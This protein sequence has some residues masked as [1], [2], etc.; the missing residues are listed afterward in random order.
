MWHFIRLSVSND[1]IFQ[2]LFYTPYVIFVHSDTIS[3]LKCDTSFVSLYP[4]TK[5]HSFCVT[6]HTS[7][8]TQS[9]SFPFSIW[10]FIHT[11]VCN[12]TILYF[13]CDTSKVFWTQRNNPLVSM[14]HSMRMFVFIDTIFHFLFYTAYICLYTMTQS[15]SFYVTLHTSVRTQWNNL[16]VFMLHFIRL[17]NPMSQFSFSMWH[18]IHMLI[19][20]DTLFLSLCDNSYVCL[21]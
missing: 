3:Q 1:T 20:N 19:Q 12:D 11:F 10:H 17:S 4:V 8:C 6:F 5:C 18:F 21:C 7:F 15:S 2:F 16:P 13:P 14:W 9:N